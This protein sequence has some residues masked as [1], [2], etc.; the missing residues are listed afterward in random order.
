MSSSSSSDIIGELIVDV[1][2]CDMDQ[3]MTMLTAA[4]EGPSTQRVKRHRRY[5]N[6]DHKMA[7]VRLY[8]D[9]FNI[10][11][12]LISLTLNALLK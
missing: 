12:Y 4:M 1:L 5:V 10:L 11:I 6:R 2:S 8:H 3:A 9:Y 7:H